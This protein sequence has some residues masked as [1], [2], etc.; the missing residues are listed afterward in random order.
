[1]KIKNQTELQLMKILFKT[2]GQKPT[3][4]I[5]S[6]RAYPHGIEQKYFRQLQSYFKPLTDYVKKY[7]SE[8]LNQ[9]LRGDSSEI[10]LDA[11]PG[12]AF[13]KMLY[14]LENWLSVYMPD[15]SELPEDSNNNVIFAGLG[16]TAD[17]TIDFSEKQFKKII[18]KGIHVDL[19]TTAEWWNKMKTSWMED[20]YTLI[21]SNAKRY[22]SQINSIVEQGVVN[23]WSVERVTKELL[24]ETDS[25]TKKHCKLL[26][27]DQIGKLS[28]QITQAQNEELG[29][30]LYV[31]DTSMD[32]RVRESH[33]VMQGLLCRWDDASVCSYDNG[34]TWVPRPAD[35][36]DLHPGQDI[37]C[38]C[39][40]LTFYPELIAEVE[41]VGLEDTTENL[42]PVRD[43][44]ILSEDEISNIKD[45]NKANSIYDKLNNEY[46]SLLDSY[47]SE[48]DEKIKEE[49]LQK[50]KKIANL[51]NIAEARKNVLET[52]GRIP[53]NYEEIIQKLETVDTPYKKFKI[54][55]DDV[56]NSIIVG[57]NESEISALKNNY[58][59]ALRIKDVK[60]TS[61]W[62]LDENGLF[63]FGELNAYSSKGIGDLV[64]ISSDMSRE[65]KIFQP[66]IYQNSLG[67]FFDNNLKYTKITEKEAISK[68]PKGFTLNG[69][70]NI[71]AR[72]LQN[73][74]HFTPYNKFLREGGDVLSKKETATIKKVIDRTN[75]DAGTFYRGVQG[76]FANKLNS[77]KIG[78]TFTEKSFMST[79]SDFSVA[80]NFAGEEGVIMKIISKGGP[81][82]SIFIESSEFGSESETLFNVNSK[83]KL[84]GKNKNVLEFE[85]K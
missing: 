17:E 15:I 16:K 70:S 48:T 11:I 7:L 54:M 33:A 80:E 62:F 60:S 55:K 8:N 26:A 31:W 34:K 37:Q 78:D 19:P 20:N 3:K 57:K 35:A 71:E 66:K 53:N 36:V 41:N 18:E 1:M 73:Y 5:T 39:S 65:S 61:E 40:A 46:K 81:G 2:S 21:T 12:N 49:I 38:R 6:K 50:G 14:N 29:L 30:E 28:G 82:K 76:E 13:D 10:K 45:I 85:L 9:I 63:Q 4:N 79:S 74:T 84:I 22:V 43:L 58:L 52:I 67:E 44:E 24:K 23:G 56:T 25:L 27:R 77:M 32:D 75:S 68:I 47:R 64:S 72:E 69:V 42:P 59:K 83:L 51:K